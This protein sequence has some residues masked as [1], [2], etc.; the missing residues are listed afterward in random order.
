METPN[1]GEQF[2]AGGVAEP[3]V[4]QNQGHLVPGLANPAQLVDCGAGRVRARD[5]IVGTVAAHQFGM[6]PLARIGIGF[7]RDYG[8]RRGGHRHPARASPRRRGATTLLRSEEGE[9]WSASTAPT[10]ETIAMV[11][12]LPTDSSPTDEVRIAGGVS[13]TLCVPG[14]RD[15]RCEMSRDPG[16]PP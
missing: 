14:S 3:M 15:G 4:R 16:W 10:V 11:L 2:R 1:P 13:I 5:S 12:A 8:R 9:R 6:D 7:D